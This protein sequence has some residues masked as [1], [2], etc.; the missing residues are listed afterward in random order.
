M[1]SIYL[2]IWARGTTYP[3][4]NVDI[5]N[6]LEARDLDKQSLPPALDEGCDGAVLAM[7]RSADTI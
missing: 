5:R 4:R 1:K 3:P 6:E 2:K 7:L